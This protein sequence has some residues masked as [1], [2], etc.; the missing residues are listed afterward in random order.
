MYFC[1]IDKLLDD[2]QTN[3]YKLCISKNH[4]EVTL[5]KAAKFI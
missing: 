4:Q 1:L 5:K 3:N 2:N